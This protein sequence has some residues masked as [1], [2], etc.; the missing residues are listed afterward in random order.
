MQLDQFNRDSLYSKALEY[1]YE[2]WK[3]LISQVKNGTIGIDIVNIRLVLLDVINE[4]ELNKFESDNNRKVYIK[5]IENLISERH[6]KL[7]RDEL[8]ILKGKLERKDSQAVY[9]I[10]KE[11]SKKFLK[12]ILHKYYLTNY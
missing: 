11:L 1:W 10:A 4:Y 12:Q 9:V 5:L 3:S 2:E 7:Y 6:M 8:L